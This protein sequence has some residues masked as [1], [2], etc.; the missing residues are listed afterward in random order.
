MSLMGPQCFDIPTQ[1]K[2]KSFCLKEGFSECLNWDKSYALH[3]YNYSHG[4]T[5]CLFFLFHKN[6]CVLILRL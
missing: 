4:S 1:N 2:R 6:K 3:L 5:S